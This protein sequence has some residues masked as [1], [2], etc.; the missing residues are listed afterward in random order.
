MRRLRAALL[1]L[2]LALTLLAGPAAAESA[3]MVAGGSG[4]RAVPPPVKHVVLFIAGGMQFANPIAASRYLHGRDDGLSFQRFPY[5][6]V[7]ATW[8]RPTYDAHAR[9]RGLPAYDPQAI[10]PALGYDAERGGVEPYPLQLR[11]SDDAYLFGDGL[12]APAA[13]SAEAAAWAVATGLKGDGADIGRPAHWPR[14]SPVLSLV[15]RLQGERQMALGIVSTEA[16]RRSS[17][18]LIG[19]AAR[20]LLGED[21][22]YGPAGTPQAPEVVIVAADGPGALASRAAA[23]VLQVFRLHEQGVV[24]AEPRA[25]ERGADILALAAQEA[26][27]R[28]SP[29]VGVFGAGGHFGGAVAVASPRQPEIRPDNGDDPRLADATAAALLVLRQQPLGFVAIIEQ[30]GIASANAAGH[31]A[32]AVGATAELDRAVAAAIDVI[33]LPDDDVTWENTLL[34]VAADRA[35]GQLRLAGAAPLGRGELPLPA[36]GCDSPGGGCAGADA[37]ADG[38]YRTRAP[39]N[40]LVPLSAAGA[41]ATLFRSVEGLWYPCTRIIDNVQIH[42][43]LAEAAG[44][45]VLPRLTAL[46]DGPGRCSTA[47]RSRQRTR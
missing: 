24:I 1:A 13:T 2:M 38:L 30:G 43:V 42:Q 23:E 8:D 4:R 21:A 26:R 6:G 17:A 36:E 22:A 15:Q 31:F 41:A 39:G 12:S 20:P 37:G 10:W 19:L 34:V 27:D 14:L 45:P 16:V 9:S 3:L 32:R 25:G 7:V 28:R 33:N 5:Q 11:G 44:I 47:W 46:V 35:V 40:A 29:L 18:A